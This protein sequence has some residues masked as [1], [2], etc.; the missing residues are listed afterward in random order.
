MVKWTYEFWEKKIADNFEKHFWINDTPLP[1]KEHKV[2]LINRR[3]IYKDTHNSSTD[4]ADLQLRP[5]FPIALAVVSLIF[6]FLY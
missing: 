1:N 5:N 3:G 4:W 2:D 6:N